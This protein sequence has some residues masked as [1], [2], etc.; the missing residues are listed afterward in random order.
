VFENK[1][2]LVIGRNI[3]SI[4]KNDVKKKTSDNDLELRLSRLFIE[5]DKQ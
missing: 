2:N 3:K 4:I 5:L 1:N